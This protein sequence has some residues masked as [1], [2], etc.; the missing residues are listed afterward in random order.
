VY[1]SDSEG[2]AGGKTAMT[3]YTM[4]SSPMELL[5]VHVKFP[6]ECSLTSAKSLIL[7]RCLRPYL[8][9]LRTVGN[10]S[11]SGY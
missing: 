5:A 8:I 7:S 1:W 3:V 9:K 6:D 2:G 4:E 11:S 10:K